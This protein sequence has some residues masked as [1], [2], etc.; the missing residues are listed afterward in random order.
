M[1]TGSG[2]PGITWP[3]S[4]DRGNTSARLLN[5][6]ARILRDLTSAVA[7]RA[8]RSQ[9]GDCAAACNTIK[10]RREIRYRATALRYG[11]RV[12]GRGA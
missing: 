8:S 1:A 12:T 4:L 6:M 2:Q 10:A 9:G 5:Q 7:A 3:A 11:V